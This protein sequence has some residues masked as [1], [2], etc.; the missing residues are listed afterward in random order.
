M[1]IRIGANGP[2]VCFSRR[3]PTTAPGS[4]L[5]P[6]ASGARKLS[7]RAP[8]EHSEQR[9]CREGLARFLASGYKFL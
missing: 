6:R 8:R 5:V 1:V 9:G 7:R 2:A 3:N 4:I